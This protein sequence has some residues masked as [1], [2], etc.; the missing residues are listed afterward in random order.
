MAK[1]WQFWKK[2]KAIIGNEGTRRFQSAVMDRLTSSWPISPMTID[3]DIRQNHTALVARMRDLAQNDDYAVRHLD[4]TDS[5]VL[6][7]NGLILVPEPR[8]HSGK[9]DTTAAAAIAA[10][11]SEW[12]KKGNCDVTGQWSWRDIC[13]LMLQAKKRDGEGLLLLHTNFAGNKWRFAVQFIDSLQLD[14]ELN[15]TLDSGNEIVMGVELNRLRR[16]VSYHFREDERNVTFGNQFTGRKHVVF[17]A[18]RVVHYFAPK[19]AHQTRGYSDMASAAKRLNHIDGWQE[20][21]L[22]AAR[23]H[24]NYSMVLTR[25]QENQGY[26]GETTGTDGT[27]TIQS[28]P[29]DILDLPYAATAHAFK[30]EH[31]GTTMPDGLKAWLRGAAS[32]LKGSYNMLA[33]DAEGV[34]FSSIRIFEL[35]DQKGYKIQQSEL[36]RHVC[37]PVHEAFNENS[38]LLGL[39]RVSSRPL[40]IGNQAKYCEC[41]WQA[42]G[43]AW[44][45]PR[46]DSKAEDGS[47]N[48]KTRSPQDVIRSKGKDPRRVLQEFAEWDDMLS[49]FNLNTPEPAEDKESSDTEPAKVDLIK[50]E[51]GDEKTDQND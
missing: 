47:M 15:K 25:N 3:S 17:P 36:G 16:P 38:L 37:Q 12:C 8:N 1:F 34:S 10:N 48:N 4:L 19:F 42:P 5:N 41:Y 39:L 51:K 27:R 43:F 35:Q 50:Q 14:V 46:A 13:G 40:K 18:A 26:T 31:P 7:E 22:V 44:V 28:D 2:R 21:S 30:P 49:E 11:W 24:A 20:A 45:D 23:L 33:N 6:G 9:I 32:G 29:G